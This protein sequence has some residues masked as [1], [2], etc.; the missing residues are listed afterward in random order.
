MA[1]RMLQ[2]VGL[3]KVGRQKIVKWGRPQLVPSE[4]FGRVI[5]VCEPLLLGNEKKYVDDCLKT[6]W[7]SSKGKYIVSFEASFSK[8]C[9]QKH[10][11]A[12]T[13][14]TTALHL[15]LHA[16]GITC[17]DE[18]IVPTSTIISN[19][20]AVALTGAKPV[21]IDSEPRTW[22]LDPSLIE[23]KI[24]ER[25]KAITPVHLYGHPCDMDAVRQVADR[26]D[27]WII[28]DAAE[29]FGATY[30]GN[31]AGSLGDAAAFSLYANKMIT[32]GEG[33]MVVTD[34]DE[35]AD[36]MRSLR[37]LAFSKETHFWHHYLGFNY[38][39]TNLQAAIGLAQLEKSEELINRRIRNADL[40][41]A[42]LK[43][44]PGI[45][46]PPRTEGIKNVFWMYSILIDDR[47]GVDRDRLI[48]DLGL[49]GIEAKTFF[50]PLHLQ[51]IYF[52]PQQEADFPVAENL[53]CR[54]L[55]LPSSGALTEDEIDYV[56]QT[57]REIHESGR[58]ASG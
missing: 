32:T 53:A 24:T 40:Y 3:S 30:K 51:P 44:I 28:E 25:T 31:A 52:D 29:A 4:R 17:G 20:N 14:G 23:E 5:P 16:A 10:G 58:S 9:G 42:G 45:I 38:R 21:F 37:D 34:N 35:L 19:A 39:M 33:G 18:V 8:A 6:N 27:L 55:Y 57:I 36:L 47:F 26:Y 7:I 56:V 15:I 46:L 1:K 43:E 11:I 22:N 12:C 48:T 50:I 49:R 2:P 13:S 54:G 41:D